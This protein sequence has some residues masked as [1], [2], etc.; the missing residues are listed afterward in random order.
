MKESSRTPQSRPTQE[1]DQPIA[2]DAAANQPLVQN[3]I[4]QSDA[5]AYNQ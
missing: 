5:L 1:I 4:T 2:P 3:A